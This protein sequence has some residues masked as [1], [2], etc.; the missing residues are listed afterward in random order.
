V[1]ALVSPSA[2]DPLAAALARRDRAVVAL[3]E[4]VLELEARGI[5]CGVFSQALRLSR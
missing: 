2:T 1:I 3:W 5:D 4:R